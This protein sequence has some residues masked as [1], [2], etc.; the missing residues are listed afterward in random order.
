M[1]RLGIVGIGVIARDYINLI[2]AGMVQDVDLSAL[3]SR[4]AEPARQLTERYGLHAVHYQDYETMLAEGML[5]GVL[6]CTPHGMHPAMTRQALEAGL[7]VLVEKPVGIY[8][9]NE[10]SPGTA[11]I[12][13][14]RY[15][16]RLKNSPLMMEKMPSNKRPPSKISSGHRKDRGLSSAVWLRGCGPCRSSTALIYPNGQAAERRPCP[17]MR[18]FSGK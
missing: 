7:H 12:S 15:R 10:T 18:R 8:A 9:D 3:C 17:P 4:R 14:R 6:I 16:A 13:L 2:S 11:L 5:D 1:F